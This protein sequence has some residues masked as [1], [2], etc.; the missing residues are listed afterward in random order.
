MA[1]S[2]LHI[3]AHSLI[4]SGT[5]FRD[6]DL[7]IKE[8]TAGGTSDFFL[9]IYKTLRVDYPKFYK[10]DNLCKLGFLA[11]EALLKDRQITEAYAVENIGIVLSNANSSLD[12]DLKYFESVK[13]I[14]SPAL[15]VYTLPNIVIGE[16][17]IR[18]GI[19]GENAFFISE[20]FDAGFIQ[21]YVQDL[22]MRNRVQACICGWVDYF[23]DAY[24]A[25][26]YL[27]EK[28]PGKH[29]LIFNFANI[30]KI[31]ELANGQINERSEA[32]DYS[33]IKP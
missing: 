7:I 17:S 4:Y 22:F 23:E 3:T 33:A 2:D 20:D 5:V 8:E 27:V 31:Y 11:A 9:S 15:F 24:Q 13:N 6:G 16:L 30:Q 26:L 18:H 10:M 32:P 25:A 1:A 12:A 21:F 19:K 29:K 14:P 28:R